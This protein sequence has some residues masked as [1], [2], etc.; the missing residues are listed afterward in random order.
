VGYPSLRL[1]TF[2]RTG[3]RGIQRGGS[4]LGNGIIKG[5]PVV[6]REAFKVVGV[7]LGGALY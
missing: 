4:M 7:E 3:M 5:G 2:H 6:A 1:L